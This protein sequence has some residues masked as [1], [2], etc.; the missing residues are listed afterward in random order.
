VQP[1]LQG[2]MAVPVQPFNPAVMGPLKMPLLQPQTLQQQQQ[3]QHVVPTP[4]TVPVVAAV[5][6]TPLVATTMSPR[7]KA[8][9]PVLARA[10]PPPVPTVARVMAQE[11]SSAA[12]TAAAVAASQGMIELVA[13][14]EGLQQDS[15]NSARRKRKERPAAAAGGIHADDTEDDD[16]EYQP[17]APTVAPLA[18][19]ARSSGSKTSARRTVFDESADF[20][21]DSGEPHG[22]GHSSDLE[23]E[24]PGLAHGGSSAPRPPVPAAVA[25]LKRGELACGSIRTPPG[26]KTHPFRTVI[27]CGIPDGHGGLIQNQVVPYFNRDLDVYTAEI[28]RKN[29]LLVRASTLADKFHCATNKIGMYLARRRTVFPGI[30]QATEFSQ[31]PLGR[32]GLKIGGYFLTIDACLDFEAHFHLHR[33]KKHA[34]FAHVRHSHNQAH[35]ANTSVPPTATSLATPH[36]QSNGTGNGVVRGRRDHPARA[37]PQRVYTEYDEDGEVDAGDAEGDEEEEPRAPVEDVQASD[38]EDELDALEDSVPVARANKT[39]Q[40]RTIGPS[41]PP[42]GPSLHVVK[43]ATPV[44]FGP[45][46]RSSSSSHGDVSPSDSSRRLSVGK[47][48]LSSSPSYS[49]SA[50]ATTVQPPMLSRPSSLQTEGSHEQSRSPEQ[51]DLPPLVAAVAAEA[52][53]SLVPKTVLQSQSQQATHPLHYVPSGRSPLPELDF[54]SKILARRAST[55]PPSANNFARIPLLSPASSP[56]PPVSAVAL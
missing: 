7:I 26:T 10:V 56:S 16:A 30:F 55:S 20:S 15:A 35:H 46:P 37:K 29:Q 2:N 12:A 54:A 18:K 17:P 4:A 27:R 32:T 44:L 51:E 25:L 39:Q 5:A 3:Q 34:A 9:M 14:A 53:T 13:A 21:H 28:D 52:L 36:A 8:E 49:S 41:L 24:Q 22:E 47:A 38:N 33:G 6:A 19:R 42:Q 40:R 43:L 50:T 31:K 48:T 45:S 23:Y 1:S 11:S